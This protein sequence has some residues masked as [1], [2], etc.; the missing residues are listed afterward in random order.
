MARGSNGPLGN[1]PSRVDMG[2]ASTTLHNVE[3]LALHRAAF[4]P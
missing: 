2:D 4:G 3:I 1:G